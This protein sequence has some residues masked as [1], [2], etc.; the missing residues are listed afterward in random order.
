MLHHRD[1]SLIQLE[2]SGQSVWLDHI[3]RD[4]LDDGSLRKLIEEDGISGLTSNPA[5]FERAIES[6]VYAE[7]IANC[8]QEG[9]SPSGWRSKTS[10]RQQKSSLPCTRRAER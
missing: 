8:R 10:G 2:S 7:A 9:L 1:N 6:G 4:L 5:I 3:R